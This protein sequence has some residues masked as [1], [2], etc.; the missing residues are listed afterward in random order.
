MASPSTSTSLSNLLQPNA[1]GH[2]PLKGMYYENGTV[3]EQR[4]EETILKRRD[5]FTGLAPIFFLQPTSKATLSPTPADTTL[6][7]STALLQGVNPSRR[8]REFVKALR[9]G[10]Y[11]EWL[12]AIRGQAKRVLEKT[13]PL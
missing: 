1:G 11:D 3:I 10:L 7:L 2:V 5:G 12:E 4:N 13:E 9:G 6:K 8:E